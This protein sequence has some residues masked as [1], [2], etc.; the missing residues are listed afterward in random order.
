MY[1]GCKNYETAAV[2][3]FIA[4][5]CFLQEKYSARADRLLAT[6]LNNIDAAA[7]ELADELQQRF[8]ED[9]KPLLDSSLYEDLLSGAVSNVDWWEV[10]TRMFGK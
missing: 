4:G 5:D 10:A 7:S 8:A 6:H 3:A 9:D 2:C 1:N